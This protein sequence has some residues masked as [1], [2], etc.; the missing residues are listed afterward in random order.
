[1][2][3]AA[4]SGDEDEQLAVHEALDHLAAHDARKAELVKLRYFGADG[5]TRLGLRARLAVS[6]DRSAALLSRL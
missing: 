6:G 4:P 2:Q 1:M 3:I 5:Q